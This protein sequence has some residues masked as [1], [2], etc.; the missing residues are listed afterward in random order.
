MLALWIACTEPPLPS[1]VDPHWDL[2]QE[3]VEGG[4]RLRTR[5]GRAGVSPI[6]ACE[7][8]RTATDL[9]PRL[10]DHLRRRR[11]TSADTAAFDAS[12][13]ALPMALPGLRVLGSNAAVSVAVD[14]VELASAV[15]SGSIEDDL[16]SVGALV[17]PD[18]AWRGDTCTHPEQAVVWFGRLA[19]NWEGA[20]TCFQDRVQPL[21]AGVMAEICERPCATADRDSLLP[22]LAAHVVFGGPR[23]EERWVATPPDER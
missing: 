1:W 18:A 13:A 7:A 20:T 14:Y 6:A 9:A 19:R 22:K 10:D 8:L 3:H 11:A 16:V 5:V 23:C 2:S 12:L 17:S 15:G 21:L 4:L